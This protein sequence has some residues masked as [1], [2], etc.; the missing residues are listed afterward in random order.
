MVTEVFLFIFLNPKNLNSD[1]LSFFS[2]FKKPRFLKPCQTALPL[3]AASN[4][5][6]MKNFRFS[7]NIS[8]YLKNDTRQTHSYYRMRIG[9]RTQAFE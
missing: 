5:E 9:N 7:A 6:D 2:F 8:L 1:F 3:T 4:A